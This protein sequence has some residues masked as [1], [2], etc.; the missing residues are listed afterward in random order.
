MMSAQAT[1]R[2]LSFVIWALLFQSPQV[3]CVGCKS[4]NLHISTGECFGCMV[5]TEQVRLLVYNKFLMLFLAGS[6]PLHEQLHLERQ[7]FLARACETSLA[8]CWLVLLMFAYATSLEVTL[9]AASSSCYQLSHSMYAWCKQS[10]S[11]YAWRKQ[12]CSIT[13]TL[14]HGARCI[15]ELVWLQRC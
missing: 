4:L 3:T 6:W 5:R 14:L 8:C 13:C 1:G 2:T 7:G 11:M 12:S 15:D 9:N 10:C